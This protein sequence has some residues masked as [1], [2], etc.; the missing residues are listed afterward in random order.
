MAADRSHTPGLVLNACRSCEERIQAAVV[1][2]AGRSWDAMEMSR[3]V[4][5]VVAMV[6]VSCKV[7]QL[8]GFLW[9]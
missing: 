3:W 1:L 7:P 9:K 4:V 5:V 6:K 2:F 8:F